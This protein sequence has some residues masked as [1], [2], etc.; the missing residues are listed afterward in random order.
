ML[1]RVEEEVPSVSDV[2]KADDI[3]LQ[4]IRENAAKSTEDL[5]AQLDN[6]THSPGDSLEHPL[7][8]HLGLDKELRNIWGSLKVETGEKVQLQECI[9]R[10]SISSLKSRKT[11]NMRMVF[12]KTSGK[13]SRG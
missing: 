2:A 10:E 6:P 4:E 1:K 9:E 5:I 13:G 11:K 8:E 12:K 7:H 3:E